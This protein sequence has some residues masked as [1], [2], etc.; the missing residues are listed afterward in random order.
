MNIFKVQVQGLP[1]V[2]RNRDVGIAGLPCSK[3]LTD[4][5]SECCLT[6][7]ISCV[8][9]I[10]DTISKHALSKGLNGYN[11]SGKYRSG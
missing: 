5:Y 7:I 9:Y 3:G 6:F 2:S 4:F 1:I 8:I 10:M 11:R